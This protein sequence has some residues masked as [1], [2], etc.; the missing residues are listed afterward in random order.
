[1]RSRS[2]LAVS[3]VLVA[4]LLMPVGMST[5]VALS[6]SPV[7]AHSV[8]KAVSKSIKASTSLSSKKVALGGST[9]FTISATGTKTGFIQVQRRLASG[10]WAG[11]GQPYKYTN[12]SKISSTFTVPNATPGKFVYRYMIIDST[13]DFYSPSYVLDVQKE[14]TKAVLSLFDPNKGLLKFYVNG[15]GARDI[16]LQKN[17][18]KGWVDA[19]KSK[20]FAGPTTFIKLPATSTPA[21]WR[22]KVLANGSYAEAIS[23]TVNPVSGVKGRAVAGVFATKLVVNVNLDKVNTN[24]EVSLIANDGK[25]IRVL[26]KTK[27]STNGSATFSLSAGSISKRDKLGVHVSPSAVMK[28]SIIGVTFK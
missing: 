10:G 14:S 24:K 2:S 21:S 11:I 5:S 22:V 16:M 1:M 23:A 27:T 20:V 6:S 25:K 15:K 8:S 28:D 12:K 19:S 18:G 4:G 9:K 3:G 13:G 7:V 17:T 26:A